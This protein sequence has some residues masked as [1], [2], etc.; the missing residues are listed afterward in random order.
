MRL[1]APRKE[2][3]GTAVE[4]PLRSERAITPWRGLVLVRVLALLW[5]QELTKTINKRNESSAAGQASVAGGKLRVVS[6]PSA[7]L[8]EGGYP[9][10]GREGWG[11]GARMM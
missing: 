3:E 2:H 4:P 1:N 11:K 9:R 8:R 5:A 7:Q 6:D 10:G